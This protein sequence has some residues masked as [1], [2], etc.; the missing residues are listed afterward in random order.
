MKIGFLLCSPD[1]SGGTNVIFQHAVGLKELG[2][3]VSI[4]TEKYVVPKRYAWHESAEHLTWL[5][6]N[7]AAGRSFDIIVATW[8]ESPYLLHQFDSTHFV[9]FVQSI[10]SKF[11]QPD[12]PSNLDYRDHSLGADRCDHGYFFSLPVITEATWIKEFLEEHYNHYPFLVK[13]GIRKDLYKKLEP[14]SPRPKDRLRVLVEGPV[15]VFHKNVPRTIEL[16]VE[17]G[18]DE[19]WLL[20]PSDVKEFPGVHRVFSRLPFNETPSVYSSCNVLVKLSYVEGMFGPPL[21]MFHC[22]GTAIVYGVTGCDEYI[23]HNKNSLIVKKDDETGVVECLRKLKSQPDLCAELAAKAFETAQ[24]WPDWNKST[25]LFEKTL[26]RISSGPGVSR[27]YLENIS[28][29]FVEH[30]FL[31]LESRDLKNFVSRETRKPGSSAK[32]H[33]FIKSY[34]YT[35]DNLIDGN[36]RYYEGSGRQTVSLRIDMPK[37]KNSIRLDP[38]VR[39]GILKIYSFEVVDTTGVVLA[40]FSPVDGFEKLYLTGTAQWIKKSRRCWIVESVGNDPQI[41]LPELPDTEG[42]TIFLAIDLQEMAFREYWESTG[43]P[44]IR[45]RGNYFKQ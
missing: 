26:K 40:R 25:L 2:H 27:K 24:A 34:I 13:N 36:W 5:D 10:E 3:S 20:T 41:V 29:V 30:H 38:S 11:F 31:Q 17:A 42:K 8:W 9:Y 45:K 35:R 7:Q 39:I 12:D 37:G 1:M 32:E 44:S 15:E 22:G 16:C 6:Y 43:Y 4:I 21:E 19:I 18:V 33:N 14:V 28:K 23:E